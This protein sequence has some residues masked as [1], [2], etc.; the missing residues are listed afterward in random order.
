MKIIISL[1]QFPGRAL[2]EF[3]MGLYGLDI[4]KIR[5][6]RKVCPKVRGTKNVVVKSQ[7]DK[8]CALLSQGTGYLQN[9]RADSIEVGKLKT[10]KIISFLKSYVSFKSYTC[11]FVNEFC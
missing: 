9:M 8:K 3:L 11:H 6:N 7:E 5:P 4:F 2:M 10:V 1:Q